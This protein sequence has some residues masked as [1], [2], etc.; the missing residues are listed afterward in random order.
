[1]E[2]S[3]VISEAQV[4]NCSSIAGLTNFQV[5]NLDSGVTSIRMLGFGMA[6]T[7]LIG[8]SIIRVVRSCVD[9]FI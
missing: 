9:T 6:F 4:C 5:K 1:L 7:I 2:Y 3:A 8:A